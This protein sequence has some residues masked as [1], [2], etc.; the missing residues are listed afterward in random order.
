LHAL[1]ADLHAR[2]AQVDAWTLDAH[3]PEQ[4]ALARRLAAQGVDRITTNDA[5]ALAQALDVDVVC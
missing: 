5:P 4:V 2:D 1:N 3:R